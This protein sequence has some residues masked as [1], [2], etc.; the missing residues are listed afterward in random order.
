M[1][2]G[3][4]ARAR[5][6][7]SVEELEPR[8]VMSTYFV[9]T[10]GNDQAAGSQ[11]APWQTLQHA[12]NL[13]KTGDTVIVEAGT[14]S[15]FV[16]GW[17]GAQN[18]TAS[19]PITF[20]AQPGVLINARNAQTADGIDLEGCSYVTLQ[21]FQ[22]T[23]PSGGTITRAGIRAAGTS[24]GDQI[25]NNTVAN[26]GT[27]DILTGF[28][29]NILIQ[30][31]TCSGAQSQHGIYVSNASTGPRV[32]GNTCYNNAQCGIQ[33]NGDLSQ[34][35]TGLI[36]SALIADNI[37]H[38]NGAS[39]GSGINCDGVQ[40]ST[41]ENNL[42]YNNHA[43]GISLFQIDGAAGS[44]NNVVVNNTIVMASNARWA[45]NIQNASTGNA[46]YNNL[47]FNNNTAH[48]SI[49]ISSDS[50]PG[51]TSDDNAVA[52]RFTADGGNTYLTLAQWQAQTGQDQHSFVA[53]P[54]AAFAN[55]TNNDYHLSATS[56]AIDTGTATDAPST[57]LDGNPR[58]SGRTYDVGAYEY[59]GSHLGISA[60]GGTTA[61]S[62]FTVTVSALGANNSA[63][64]SY[65]GTVHFTSSDGQ[66]VLPAD[67]TFTAADAGVHSF[68]VTL[69]TAGS[70]TV[71]A[72]DTASSA[73]TATAS[74]TVSP[75]ALS[76]LAVAGYPG[77]VSAG[78]AHNF[79]VT[80]QDTYG[81]TV[82]GY[83]GTTSFS[84]GDPAATLPTSYTF[85][86]ADAGAHAFSASFNTAGTQSLTARDASAGVSGQQTGIQVTAG[87][88]SAGVSGPAAG[89]PGQSLA[90]TLTATESGLPSATVYS[91][92]ID[93]DGNGTVDQTVQGTTGT[94]VSYVYTGTGNFTVGVTATDPSG[95]VSA[96]ATAPVAITTV[97]LE[98]DP[99]S[100]GKTALFVGGT[101]GGDT[102]AITPTNASGGLSVTVNGV[103]S[104]GLAPTGDVFVYGQAGNDT[105]KEVSSVI[106]GTTRYVTQPAFLFGGDGND[107]LSVENGSTANNVLVGGNGNDTLQGAGGRDLLIGGAGT[108]VLK[109]GGGDD[110]LIGGGTAYDNNLQ[111]LGAIMAEW[112][113]TGVSY[114][115]RINFLN[116]TTSGGLN[117][118][119]LL[120][121]TTVL[122]DGAADT[123]Y[124]APGSDW[125]FTTDSALKLDRVM[126]AAS[127][128]VITAL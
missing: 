45:L 114:L 2:S 44:K 108:D 46:V 27:W 109:G 20:Q 25:L 81:N 116:G 68:T 85:T 24:T 101:T 106:S 82:T 77:S 62:A 92:A 121:A 60:P 19:S 28:A 53:T 93:W 75:G 86:A 21:G 9:A 113:Q 126:D 50:L 69:K 128:E 120:N 51:F 4:Q 104:S 7:L 94:T 102:I 74:L 37:V 125:F 97:A 43:S 52:N 115:N 29:S 55:P 79:T 63:L 54:T 100:A 76:R 11:L 38:D 33:L 64:A 39:G 112:G 61:G 103:T 122:A 78:T 117:G 47:L 6:R 87:V 5:A 13:V 15:G 65:T 71:T 66:A 32:I 22:V 10:T 99:L 89:V 107:L 105:I 48:G 35:G 118:S 124:G 111:A 90:F 40:N 72:T 17:N 59:Q 98:S 96:P 88:P 127:G 110:L 42:L 8:V 83:T 3:F 18:G 123:L 30:G 70:R 26:C 91:F 34:G 23:N 36:T 41:I 73:L 95:Q 16:M 84:S 1:R 67:Y 58:P 49:D 31:N 56:P 57:D 119:Y 14:Y 12:A 80:A